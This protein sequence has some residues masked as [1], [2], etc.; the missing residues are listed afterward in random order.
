MDLDESQWQRWPEGGAATEVPRATPELPSYDPPG[1]S[2]GVLAGMAGDCLRDWKV[3]DDSAKTAADT[4]SSAVTP[5]NVWKHRD[6]HPFVLL[7]LAIDLYG[8]D[9]V[10]WLP[11][12][13]KMTF[14]RDGRA[15]SNSAFTKLMAAR[16]LLA[17][18]S[19]WRQWEVFHWISRGLAGVPPNFTFLEE[20]ELGEMAVCADM[21]RLTDPH[22]KTSTEVDKFVAAVFKH[23]GIHFAPP[24]LDFAQREIEQ[25]QISCPKCSAVHRDD[26][27]TK[28]I[29]CGSRELTK[30]PYVF[31]ESRDATKALWDARSTLPLVTAVDG[32]PDGGAG[33]AVYRLLV[34]WDYA[35]QVRAHLL[36]QLRMIGGHR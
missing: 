28:C 18:P 7:L 20:P 2:T 29:S 19:P 30:L 12:T 31:A 16:T 21:M 3:T 17:T 32:L 8:E 24:P 4:A 25:G 6:S 9:V 11:D 22:R 1:I 34:Q 33:N 36:Q 27:D 5:E 14:E 13:V 23:E 26:G 15:L 10:Y 35:R